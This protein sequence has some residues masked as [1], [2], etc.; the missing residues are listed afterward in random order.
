[1]ISVGFPLSFL[2]DELLYLFVQ[3]ASKLAKRNVE[4]GKK[5]N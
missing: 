1:M 4:I 2:G 3:G 5:E